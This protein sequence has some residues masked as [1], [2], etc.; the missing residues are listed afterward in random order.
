MLRR[1][2]GPVKRRPRDLR[3]KRRHVLR[4]VSHG[5]ALRPSLTRPPLSESE[6][7][8]MP[9]DGAIERRDFVRNNA[10]E[11][12]RGIGPGDPHERARAAVPASED[13]C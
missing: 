12:D 11:E 4:V 13:G 7:A 9:A 6:M 5:P 8:A 3:A 2:A 10:L 1:G